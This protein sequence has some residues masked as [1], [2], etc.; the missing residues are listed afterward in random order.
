MSECIKILYK[1][2]NVVIINKPT[3]MPSQSDPTGDLDAVS[4]TTESLTA[5]GENSSLW[6]VH[7][8]DR[9]VGGLIAFARNKRCAAEMSRLVAE[10]KLDK[11][12]IAVCHGEANMGRYEDL[13]FKDSSTSKAY[14]VTTERKGA[15]RAELDLERLDVKDGKSLV[16]ITLHTGRFHQIRAQLSSRGNSLVGDKKYGSRDALRKTPS[17]FSS[18]LSFTLFGKMISVNALPDTDEYP[19]NL[20][21]KEIYTKVVE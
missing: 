14:V 7:R 11:K 16:Y 19:W 6:L 17:L 4:A 3:G 8:L 5:M 2:K 10:G 1:D 9:T 13:L 18:R 12:Y 15:K 21:S 20:F